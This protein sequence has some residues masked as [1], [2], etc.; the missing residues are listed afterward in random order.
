MAR[1]LQQQLAEQEEDEGLGE[2][3]LADRMAGLDL[4][5]DTDQVWS[6]LTEQEQREFLALAE[7]GKIIADDPRPWWEGPAV[8]E[9]NATHNNSSADKVPLG[10]SNKPDIKTE[11]S[12]LTNLL[13]SK[14]PSKTVTYDVVSV[15]F[16]YCFV[17]RSSN[18]DLTSD[19]VGS[20]CE[21]INIAPA[22]VRSCC[23]SVEEAV[24]VGL[25]RT[26][27]IQQSADLIQGKKK[28]TAVQKTD[29][30]AAINIIDDI[31]ALLTHTPPEYVLR[32]LSDLWHLFGAAYQETNNSREKSQRKKSKQ[33]LL[34]VKRLEFMMSYVCDWWSRHGAGVEVTLA[35]EKEGLVN[36]IKVHKAAE[37][38][39]VGEWGKLG[40]RHGQPAIQE[41][42]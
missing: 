27:E 20:C 3:D 12:P 33:L 4:E 34:G 8:E 2:E 29:R 13:G 35:A 17:M 38:E 6:R 9:V 5:R 1:I 22:I 39:I 36:E 23:G 26:Q 7:A 37:Q 31:V 18:C 14:S 10:S 40:R 21:I 42:D 30:E 41:L 32:A 28:L 15:L 16:A 24:Q 19:V 11:I 25:S